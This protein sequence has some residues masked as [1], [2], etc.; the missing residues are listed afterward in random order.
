MRFDSPVSKLSLTLQLPSHTMQSAGIWLPLESTR[1]SSRTISSLL[2]SAILPFLRT[3]IFFSDKI[4]SLSTLILERISWTIPII[5]FA[6]TTPIKSIFLCEPT[7]INAASKITF[8]RL[9]SVNKLSQNIFLI[10]LVLIL[11]EIFTF[12][13]FTRCWTS[14]SV[15]PTRLEFVFSIY[16]S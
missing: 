10:D 1:I 12:P 3:L 8:I 13:S 14:E 2:I 6:I 15:R 5:I 9:K 16:T 7:K 4:V 11:V